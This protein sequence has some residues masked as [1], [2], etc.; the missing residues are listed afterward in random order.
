MKN[1][2]TIGEICKLYNVS[3]D[4]MRYYESKGLITPRRRENG[5]RVYSIEEIWK[6]NIIK[7]L[8]KLKFSV[9]QIKEYLEDRSIHSTQA[10]IDQGI[11]LISK[12][13][14]SLE[15]TNKNL[16]RK[17]DLLKQMNEIKDYEKIEIKKIP[18]R[19]IIL[20]EGD[21][22]KD[23]EI[24]LAFRK[25]QSINDEKV[26]LFGNKDMGAFISDEGMKRGIYNLY[27]KV[28]F[29]VENIENDDYTCLPEGDYATLVYKGA[30]KK[31]QR[32]IPQMLKYIKD[33]GYFLMGNPLEIYRV[34]IHQTAKEEEFMTEIQ[35]PIHI[36]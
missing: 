20:I 9:N 10:L 12:E 14:K 23:E 11:K 19:K 36:G 26:F 25:L 16:K 31:S 27:Q 7:D 18:P 28:F 15:D 35:I 2:Y 4:S 6:L 34:D 33:Q 32:F 17:L 8:R 21:V 30:Y 3:Q 5:Y 22:S 13:I 1:E 29:F 24:D